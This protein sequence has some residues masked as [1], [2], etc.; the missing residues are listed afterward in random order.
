MSRNS[1]CEVLLLGLALL[2]R[3]IGE[4]QA[5][6]FAAGEDRREGIVDLVH[7]P[8]GQLADG[9]EL[10]ALRQALLGLTPGG[11]IFADGDDV[12]NVF[13]IHPH[14]DFGDAVVARFAGRLRIHLDGLDLACLE[15]PIKLELEQLARLTVQHLEHFTP[16]R[17][18]A[19]HTLGARL[20]L[21]VPRPNAIAPIDHVQA[22]R[23]GVDEAKLR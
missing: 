20:A 16:Q 11:D 23:E 7:D 5:E 18:L 22:D 4:A 3:Q 21:A 2:L 17:V 6:R 8:G 19:R 9:G 12:R 15:H 10:L 13:V 1:V 14:R